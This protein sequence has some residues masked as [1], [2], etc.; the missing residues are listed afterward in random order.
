MKIKF[1]IIAIVVA[2]STLMT[3]VPG[4]TIEAKAKYK[5]YISK[6]Y[7]AGDGYYEENG[8]FAGNF[9][10]KLPSG[11]VV[12]NASKDQ[13]EPILKVS[14]GKNIF[15]IDTSFTM[16]VNDVLAFSSSSTGYLNMVY[17]AST[18]GGEV[19]YTL[20][21]VSPNGKDV[22]TSQKMYKGGIDSVKFTSPDKL[23]IVPY[24][25]KTKVHRFKKGTIK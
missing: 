14:K 2:L 9:Q 8:F 10:K 22:R 19:Y 1:F 11:L 20:L 6:V 25:G 21:T 5:T 4:Q 17:M 13:W 24:T 7:N 16:M 15:Y 23:K 18:R 3:E 12:K